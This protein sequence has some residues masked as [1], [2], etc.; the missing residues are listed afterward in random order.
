MFDFQ[1]SFA[2]PCQTC[3]REAFENLTTSERVK[4]AV[5]TA[6]RYQQLLDGLPGETSPETENLRKEYEAGKAA[7]KK[8]LPGLMKKKKTS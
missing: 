8:S 4:Q 6:R 5:A 1:I 7:A 3:T 2:S